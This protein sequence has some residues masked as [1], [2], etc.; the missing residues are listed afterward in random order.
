MKETFK[1]LQFDRK[2]RVAFFVILLLILIG[3]LINIRGFVSERNQMAEIISLDSVITQ[4]YYYKQYYKSK[5]KSSYP[6][7]KKWRKSNSRNQKGKVGEST[8]KKSGGFDGT[9]TMM[10]NIELVDTVVAETVPDDYTAEFSDTLVA[11]DQPSLAFTLSDFDPN[12]VSKDE[13]MLM[14]LPERWIDNV[15]AYRSKGGIYRKKE[16]LKKLYTTTQVLYDQIEPYLSVSDSGVTLLQ[17]QQNLKEEVANQAWLEEVILSSQF[18]DI[19]TINEETWIK[20][21]GVTPYL[22]RMI[23]KYKNLLGGYHQLEQLLEVYDLDQDIYEGILPYLKCD[24]IVEYLNI[25][26]EDINV[27]SKHPYIDYKKAKVIMRFRSQHG[28]FK[29]VDQ[30]KKVGVWKKDEFDLLKPYLS[31]GN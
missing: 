26:T 15:I 22:A 2:Q 6:S 12:L 11:K 13:L 14:Y 27:L 20:L 17:E 8:A 3:S 28:L 7:K 10:I 29:S 4:Q 16:D 19:N 1:A 21:P 23:N 18:L 25:N 5:Y 24:P 9:D 30:V 31:I